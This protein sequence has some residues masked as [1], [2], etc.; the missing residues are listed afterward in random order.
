MENF[1]VFI[2][3]HMGLFY[4]LAVTMI[5][6]MIVE[7][8]RVK[9]GHARVAPAAAVLMI[10]KDNAVVIDIRNKESFQKG[11][12]VDAV[13]LPLTELPAATK[14]LDKYKN[15][16]M[17]IVCG[18]GADSQKAAA[19]L[20]ERGYNAFIL[21]GGIRAWSGADLPLVKE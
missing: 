6:L 20:S 17:I 4:I 8:L 19:N 10:N 18:S 7:L 13:N 21:A 11:H 3:N 12:I 2:A 5:A 9:R 1:T 15:K 16:P 14:K